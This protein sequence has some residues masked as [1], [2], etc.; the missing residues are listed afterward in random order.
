MRIT[1]HIVCRED[2]RALLCLL[3]EWGGKYTV[4]N[5]QPCKKNGLIVFDIFQDDPYYGEL[6]N[7][8]T[9][10][11]YAA[12]YYSYSNE[13]IAK[14]PWLLVRGV[15]MKFDLME[16][17]NR[18]FFSGQPYGNALPA[19]AEPIVLD[20]QWKDSTRQH[21]YFSY[22]S[23]Y[24]HIFCDTMAKHILERA[25]DSVRFIPTYQKNGLL[26]DNLHYML[27][28][29]VLPLGDFAIQKSSVKMQP[30]EGMDPIEDADSLLLTMI[31]HNN[32]SKN[33]CKTP[34]VF[35]FTR[36]STWCK[37]IVSHDIYAALSNAKLTRNLKFEPVIVDGC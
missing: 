4:V 7:A 1:T 14:A 24:S 34:A 3:R 5:S 22:D 28:D 33:I 35:G 36:N 17:C 16:S 25:S 32:P 29:S 10:D 8:L 15:N 6:S 2:N 20:K 27:I 21:F 26:I 18:N 31:L 30:Y 9:P 11:C 13:E 37:N 19:P 23:G 12:S